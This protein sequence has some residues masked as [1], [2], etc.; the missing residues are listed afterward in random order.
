MYVPL[1]INLYTAPSKKKK[2]TIKSKITLKVDK[3][4]NKV[5]AHIIKTP[6]TIS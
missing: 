1:F 2:L 5:Y 6:Q 3:I 4:G